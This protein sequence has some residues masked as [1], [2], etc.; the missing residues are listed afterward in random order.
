MKIPSVERGCRGKTNLG[1][2]FRTHADIFA[3]K[4]GK[5]Y[6]VYECPHCG[7]HHLTTKIENAADYG[8]LLYISHQPSRPL[9][10]G[11]VFPVPAY[12][13]IHRP[14]ATR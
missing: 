8:G 11:T 9:G 7:G 1:R 3:Q 5:T 12:M 10:E 2:D 14:P 13:Q 4:H 6:G